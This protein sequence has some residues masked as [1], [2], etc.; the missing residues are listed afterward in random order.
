MHCHVMNQ[1]RIAIGS[2]LALHINTSSLYRSW[3]FGKTYSNMARNKPRESISPLRCT[4]V[5]KAEALLLL[6]DFLPYS[7]PV[8]RTIQSNQHSSSAHVV[9]TIQPSSFLHSHSPTDTK[10]CFGVAC[11]DRSHRPEAECYLFTTSEIP[12]NCSETCESCNAVLLS[13]LSYASNMPC[14][15]P[16]AGAAFSATPR[17]AH[18]K[19]PDYHLIGALAESNL[20]RLQTMGLLHPRFGAPDTPYSHLIFKPEHPKFDSVNLV[21]LPDGLKYGVLSNPEHF[22]L[23]IKR[24]DI[25]RKISTLMTLRCEAI[26]LSRQ[27][28]TGAVAKEE[29]ISWA[30][31]G[32]DGALASLHV[33]DE[34]R[35]KGLAKKLAVK[36]VK[37]SMGDEG[38]GHAYVA[39]DNL[40]SQGVCQSIGG[41]SLL[42]RY[43]VLVDLG[44]V[45]R[46]LSQFTEGGKTPN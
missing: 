42:T 31:I 16:E 13:I 30:F 6:K 25:P 18:I 2:F 4:S 36:I 11:I 34:W 33:E 1:Q 41:V 17:S 5:D 7:L 32:N 35:G 8:Y 3:N 9:S 27:D 14:P 37:G 19:N 24:T 22:R 39:P 10:K 23:V 40:P 20:Q 15:E 45:R 12:G 26:L 21:D 43:F 46:I 28:A 44:K 38:L 29:P